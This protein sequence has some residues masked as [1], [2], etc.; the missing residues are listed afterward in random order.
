MFYFIP[1]P[2]TQQ[3]KEQES[4]PDAGTAPSDADAD[5]DAHAHA[6]AF[7]STQFC[8]LEVRV[9]ILRGVR[10]LSHG[11]AACGC[12]QQRTQQ[13]CTTIA[14]VWQFPQRAPRRI[15]SP[16]LRIAV[17]GGSASAQVKQRRRRGFLQYKMIRLEP[18]GR[19]WLDPADSE[20]E[21][22]SAAAGISF[23]GGGGTAPKARAWHDSSDSRRP[24]AASSQPA[25]ESRSGWL[26]IWSLALS[27]GVAVQD[28][29]EGQMLGP[30]R[31]C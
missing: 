25:S 31:G 14:L 9:A 17:C 4:E 12:K 13:M 2:L 19:A 6:D 22:E 3:A 18:V 11:A 21:A 8:M 24:P 20:S 5:A 10:H 27:G 28:E 1:P 29:P 30:D 7:D 16:A 26:V 15:R 23:A